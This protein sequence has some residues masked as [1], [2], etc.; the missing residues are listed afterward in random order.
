MVNLLG[1][2]GY[3]YYFRFSEMQVEKVCK[4]Y[5]LTLIDMKMTSISLQMAPSLT[6]DNYFLIN[7]I[8]CMHRKRQHRTKDGTC[9]IKI[10]IKI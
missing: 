7:K 4:T 1:L 8:E 5:I 2:K 9:A 3:L 10:P 6:L